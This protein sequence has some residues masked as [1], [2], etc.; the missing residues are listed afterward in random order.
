M[1][2]TSARNA[3]H[4]AITDDV[5]RATTPTAPVQTDDAWAQSLL[6]RM[7]A[8]K[9]LA[10]FY[11]DAGEVAA[12]AEALAAGRSLKQVLREGR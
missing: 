2:T 12:A 7:A 11:A 5:R 3:I 1:T 9:V 4:Q 6:D 8:Y 10:R